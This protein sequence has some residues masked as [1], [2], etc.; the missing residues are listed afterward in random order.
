MVGSTL[1]EGSRFVVRVEGR[2][3]AA[4]GFFVEP[5]KIATNI[6]VVAHPGPIFIKSA[7]KKKIWTVEGVTAF[8][9]KNDLV[10]LKVKDE[11]TPLPLTDS[12]ALRIDQPV[13]AVGNS[14]GE[15]KITEGNVHSVRNSDKWIRLKIHT[16]LG[17]SGSAIL[18]SEGQVI[19][20]DASGD[21]LYSYVIP[22]NALK[23]LLER[24]GLTEPLTQWQKR[25][26]ISAYHY[27]TQ[28]NHRYNAERYEEAIVE[29]NKALQLNPEFIQ[30]YYGRAS[31]QLKLGV[32]EA[33]LGNVGK[34]R[35][36]YQAAI[37]DLNE[38]IKLHPDYGDAYD[39]RG[40]TR[41]K[42][43]EVESDKGNTKEEMRM[44]TAAIND[45]TQAIKLEPNGFGAY[46]GRGI[47]KS[48][49]G[50]FKADHGNVA[51]AQKLY[52]EA[53]ADL[54]QV[55]QLDLEGCHSIPL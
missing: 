8:D 46:L 17:N 2:H 27:M 12:D 20:V 19:G 42:V 13:F 14:G 38:I 45:Y 23:T 5:D 28:A 1:E 55:I 49:R 40:D 36:L 41:F 15:Y 9:V 21:H 4:S 43:S 53:I 26:Q 54:T 22:S 25:K 35:V 16:S 39:T 24:S 10:I 34:A 51:E 11:G 37:E 31:S 33:K 30:A 3:G 48:N 7:D 44:F 32:S 18:N 6:H 52:L 50:K 29:L 47:A